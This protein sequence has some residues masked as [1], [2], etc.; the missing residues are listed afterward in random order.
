MYDRCSDSDIEKVKNLLKE[1]GYENEWLQAMEEVQTGLP[2]IDNPSLKLA[3][4]KLL[5]RIQKSASISPVHKNNYIW[6][7]YAAAILIL[8]SA[9]M[10]FFRSTI[11]VHVPELARTKK[12]PSVTKDS[13]HKW[14][15]LPDGTSVQLNANSH[16]DY[17]ESFA[18][19]K[20]REVSLIGE[21]Y[22]EVKHDAAHPF[23]IHTGKIKTTVLGTA[24]NI[25]AYSA[26]RGVTV[27]VTRGRVMVQ[28]EQKTLAILTPDQQ[29]VWNG[30]KPAKKLDVN[31]DIAIE[32]K[33]SDLIMDD[34]TLADAAK[35][36]TSR[37]GMNVQFKNDKVKD[38]RF[39]AAFLN[40]NGINQV[41]SVLGDI[42]G[43][44]L[45]LKNHTI[46]I[47]GNGC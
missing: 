17:P 44:T 41:L 35:M 16:L 27:T 2:S 24:F 42:T 36:I 5:K 23:I 32:W 19:K 25:S 4:D 20:N 18:G 29:L 43:A 30:D 31:A 40:S 39:T 38:C 34:I 9:A 46:I 33:K 45:Q 15:K 1:G 11:S 13:V 8:V 37:Y 10:F 14:I 47:D 7:P 3:E 21:A 22:F 6:L 28:D 12:V 26:Q